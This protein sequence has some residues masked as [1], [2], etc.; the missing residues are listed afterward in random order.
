MFNYRMSYAE[1]STALNNVA[2][3]HRLLTPHEVTCI[4]RS[5]EHPFLTAILKKYPL[6][7]SA[8][9]L[10]QDALTQNNVQGNR[11]NVELLQHVHDVAFSGPRAS[12]ALYLQKYLRAGRR[13]DLME[14]LESFVG[15]ALDN[16]DVLKEI[17]IAEKERYRLREIECK[18][19]RLSYCSPVQ[20][21][22]VIITEFKERYIPHLK[23]QYNAKTTFV[24]DI[25][26]AL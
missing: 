23:A 3:E 14:K 18:A 19:G 25:L 24:W 7:Q 21:T 6:L 17:E 16:A 10:L 4:E 26:S 9:K 1:L 11:E 20:P 15:E 2:A 13:S 8:Q 12:T 22:Q 5:L